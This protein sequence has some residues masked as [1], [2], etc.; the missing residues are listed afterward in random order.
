MLCQNYAYVLCTYHFTCLEFN[1]HV[2]TE[3]CSLEL[4]QYSHFY[5]DIKYFERDGKLQAHAH[6]Y[7]HWLAMQMGGAYRTEK[8]PL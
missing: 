5:G 3:L 4:L 1:Y 8:L 7:T 6:T 2:H